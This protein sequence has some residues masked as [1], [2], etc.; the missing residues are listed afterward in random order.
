MAGSEEL[1]CCSGNS[2]WQPSTLR[3]TGTLEGLEEVQEKAVT[4]KNKANKP[5][6]KKKSTSAVRTDSLLAE[7]PFANA[8]IRTEFD[9]TVE[10]L[11]EVQEKAV[12]VKNKAKKPRRKKKSTSAVCTDSLLAELPFANAEI[13][14]EFDIPSTSERSL[15]KKRKRTIGGEG[16]DGTDHK[17]K[18]KHQ[19]PNYF[20]ALPITDPKIQGGILAVQDI[21]LQKNSRLSKA[22]IPIPCL[23]ITLLVIYLANDEEVSMAVNALSKSKEIIEEILQG[24][25]LVLK[26]EGIR[27]FKNEVAFV[28]LAEGEQM[29]TL[30]KVAETMRKV[31]QEEGI[32]ATDYKAFK[33]HLTFM[34]LS[35]SPKLCNQGIK[36]IDPQLYETF[37]DHWFG[38]E[39]LQRLD[40]C[41]MLK[42]KQPN[43]YFHCET[44]ISFGEK[45]RVEPDDAEL[46]SLSK[47]LVENAVLRAVQQYLEET[48]NK[49]KRTD[50]SPAKSEEAANSNDNSK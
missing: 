36:K 4:V 6:R 23:H 46:V 13:R 21:I 42:R 48:Q 15:K 45:S 11:E 40:L 10:G 49:S 32:L 31:F 20:V 37:K 50:S 9:S 16:E 35:R 47:R 30:G 7:L 38:E 39:T 26:L 43:G 3:D 44:S 14:T 5:R 12:T 34:K 28:Q 41:S 25:Q 2:N 17:K 29:T 19:H 27:N 18:K 1:T 24:R 33:P 22:L 8:E